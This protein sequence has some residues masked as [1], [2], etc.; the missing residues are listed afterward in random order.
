[1]GAAYSH[2]PEAAEVVK[3][4]LGRLLHSHVIDSGTIKAQAEGIGAED[5]VGAAKNI[6]MSTGIRIQ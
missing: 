2:N 3:A 6:T 4:S 5:H 1:M